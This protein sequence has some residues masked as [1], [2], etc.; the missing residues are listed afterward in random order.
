MG[1][2]ETA[3]ADIYDGMNEAGAWKRKSAVFHPLSGPDINLKIWFDYIDTETPE[4]LDTHI[5]RRRE[6]IRYLISELP[7]SLD[8]GESV[9]IDGQDYAI[10]GQKDLNG[11]EGEAWLKAP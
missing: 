2:F 6:Y 4:G 10:D 3:L 9:T 7:R 1:N 5:F 8:F 11:F